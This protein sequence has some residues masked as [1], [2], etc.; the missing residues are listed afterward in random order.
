MRDNTF[1]G[2]FFHLC[3]FNHIP[4]MKK[5]S[6]VCFPESFHNRGKCIEHITQKQ[7]QYRK[8]SL[9][10]WS[11]FFTKLCLR[12]LQF[13]VIFHEISILH[14][15]I[16][17]LKILLHYSRKY[18][19]YDILYPIEDH[20]FRYFNNNNFNWQETRASCRVNIAWAWV[21]S[22]SKYRCIQISLSNNM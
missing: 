12:M 10:L 11:I 21:K 4:S 18:S 20:K 1:I 13:H 3:F 5:H 19:C 7:Q 22:L 14:H 9:I 2:E 16:A 6:W 17:I 15:T 8:I